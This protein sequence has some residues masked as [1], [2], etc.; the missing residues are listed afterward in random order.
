[1]ARTIPVRVPIVWEDRMKKNQRVEVA[2]GHPKPG[3][4]TVRVHYMGMIGTGTFDGVITPKQDMKWV[5]KKIK[6]QIREAH[7]RKK[8]TH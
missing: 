1:M 4:M 5:I 6:E 8:A 3:L 7:N 2:Y